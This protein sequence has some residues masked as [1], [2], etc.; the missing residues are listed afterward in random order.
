V[1]TCLT[2]HLKQKTDEQH[3]GRAGYVYASPNCYACHARG[4][5]G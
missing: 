4:K 3:Q 1:F 5:S 2:C